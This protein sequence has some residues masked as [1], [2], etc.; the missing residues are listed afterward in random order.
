MTHRL[1]DFLQYCTIQFH[2]FLCRGLGTMLRVLINKLMD[3]T[4][5]IQDP[6]RV[7]SIFRITKDQGELI[8]LCWDLSLFVRFVSPEVPLRGALFVRVEDFAHIH[9]FVTDISTFM[10]R[11]VIQPV[12]LKAW[13]GNRDLREIFIGDL[14]EDNLARHIIHWGWHPWRL[15]DLVSWEIGTGSK[16]FGNNFWIWLCF[17]HGLWPHIACLYLP[18]LD[19]ASWHLNCLGSHES[20]QNKC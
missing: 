6:V 7:S 18:E 1:L 12:R 5:L 20:Q 17:T 15:I 10:N 4:G 2:K 8:N 9:T 13:E 16:D 19:E 3:D 11:H 14:V